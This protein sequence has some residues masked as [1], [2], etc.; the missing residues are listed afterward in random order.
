MAFAGGVARAYAAC[1]SS[2]DADADG[3]SPS[4]SSCQGCPEAEDCD[5]QDAAVHPGSEE[6]PEDDIDDDCDDKIQIRRAFVNGMDVGV[7]N[8]FTKQRAT[9]LPGEGAVQLAP[10][11]ASPQ[12]QAWISL[13]EPIEWTSGLVHAYVQMTAKSPNASCVLTLAGSGLS[14]QSTALTVG[15][16]VVLAAVTPGG[17]INGLTVSCSGTGTAKIDWATVQNGPYPWPPMVDLSA[18][19][20]DFST[21]GIGWLG[22]VGVS[23]DQSTY[24]FGADQGG[25]AWSTDGV[26]WTTANGD[27]DDWPTY[28]HRGAWDLWSPD[29][30]ELY[31]VTGHKDNAWPGGVWY[32]DDRGAHYTRLDETLVLSSSKNLT[33]CTACDEGDVGCTKAGKSGASGH[34]LVHSSTYRPPT[35]PPEEPLVWDDRLYIGVNGPSKAAAATVAIYAEQTGRGVWLYRTSTTELWRPYPNDYPVGTGLPGWTCAEST[36]GVGEC[37]PIVSALALGQTVDGTDIL[38]VGYRAIAYDDAPDRTGLFMC[39]VPEWGAADGAEYACAPINP[40]DELDVRDIEVDPDDP[41]RFFVVDGGVRYFDGIAADTCSQ[42]AESSVYQLVVDSFAPAAYTFDDTDDDSLDSPEWMSVGASYYVSD[43]SG[44][45]LDKAGCFAQYSPPVPFTGNLLAPDTLLYGSQIHGVAID[46]STDTIVAFYPSPMTNSDYDCARWFKAS[47]ADLRVGLP[48]WEPIQE[49]AE[50]DTESADNATQRRGAVDLGGMVSRDFPRQEVI[51]GPTVDAVFVDD[52]LSGA[53]DILGAMFGPF[54]IL[55]ET[56]GTTGWDSDRDL[57]DL[58]TIQIYSGEVEGHAMHQSACAATVSTCSNCRADGR[59]VVGYA[60]GDQ[61]GGDAFSETLTDGRLAA[62]VD[63]QA[64]ASGVGSTDVDYWSDWA[65][66]DWQRWQLQSHDPYY[67]PT[68]EIYKAGVSRVLIFSEGNE[69]VETEV[70]WEGV[71][72]PSSNFRK[73]NTTSGKWELLCEDP[74]VTDEWPECGLPTFGFNGLSTDRG[75]G[76][77]RLEDVEAIGEDLALILA[78][79][80]CIHVTGGV[81]DAI[82]G[83]GVFLA[84]H[85]PSTG[86]ISFEEIPF[87]MPA[88]G[89]DLDDLIGLTYAPWQLH[90]DTL[91]YQETGFVR[92]FIAGTELSPGCPV[93]SV[94]FDPGAVADANWVAWVSDQPDFC[95]ENPEHASGQGGIGAIALSR[96]GRTLMIGGGH[97]TAGSFPNPSY[98]GGAC[99]V[100]VGDVPTNPAELALEALMANDPDGYDVVIP[101]DTFSSRILTILQHRTLDDIW[102]FGNSA[103]GV[104]GGYGICAPLGLYVLQRRVGPTGDDTWGYRR[105][106]DA[107]SPLD[108]NPGLENPDISDMDWVSPSQYRNLGDQL[109]V[110]GGCGGMHQVDFTW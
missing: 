28:Q 78:S 62:E 2:C 54:W 98:K 21:S 26:D 67:D 22:F 31:V 50:S 4:G 84:T 86:D 35:A 88:G 104:C 69:E 19:A 25:L 18:T 103:G 17:A 100:D 34:L 1:P 46:E 58:D 11:G 65:T 91:G 99:V 37:A 63:C 52:G 90:I 42:E 47:L 95:E 106:L 80:A 82:G 13:I 43:P 72:A 10:V 92:A 101:A 74:T 24:F 7:W 48:A 23:E 5:D 85:D 53:P 61:G 83:L 6:D 57:E 12:S 8:V 73:Q 41:S 9:Q 76:I 81:C 97:P 20:E 14:S 36:A 39:E 27:R 110:V 94:T 71:G 87:T 109:A 107:G 77:G 30:T 51:L 29:G 32:S 108:D 68:E 79:D 89:C 33:D 102:F 59:D 38:V 60:V 15:T 40:G 70:C 55:S 16:N 96:D 64:L 56:L 93:H 49:V 3:Y 66:G 75:P 105:V 44:A 45:G